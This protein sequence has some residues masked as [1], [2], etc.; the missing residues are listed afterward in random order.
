M[1]RQNLVLPLHLSKRP[2]A[3]DVAGIL[4]KIRSGEYQGTKKDEPKLKALKRAHLI[5]HRGPDGWCLTPEGEKAFPT[6]AAAEGEDA[7]L[8]GWMLYEDNTD[9]SY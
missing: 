9:G 6:P 1:A 7:S 2:D 3:G 8:E 5:E 4:F